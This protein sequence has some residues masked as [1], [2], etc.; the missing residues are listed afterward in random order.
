MVNQVIVLAN[1]CILAEALTLAEAGG[2]DARRIPAA[3]GAGYAG[4]NML[5]RLY[6]GWSDATSRPRAMPSRC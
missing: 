2:V 4:S 1:Y 3:L 5:Q 6:P